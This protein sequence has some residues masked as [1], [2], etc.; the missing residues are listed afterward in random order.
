[1]KKEIKNYLEEVKNTLLNEFG[2]K[3]V[4]TRSVTSF[5]KNK[6]NFEFMQE[7]YEYYK[8][9]NGSLKSVKDAILAFGGIHHDLTNGVEVKY[10]NN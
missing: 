7:Q 9:C 4:K 1:M 10:A 6:N 8:E 3:L 5:F 2:K